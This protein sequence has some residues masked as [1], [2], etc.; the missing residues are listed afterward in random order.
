MNHLPTGKLV[1]LNPSLDCSELAPEQIVCVEDPPA[2]PARNPSPLDF[3]AFS[4]YPVLSPGSTLTKSPII[5]FLNTKDPRR[6]FIGQTMFQ[7]TSFPL[8]TIVENSL[9]LYDSRLTAP[10]GFLYS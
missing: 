2:V 6:S 1:Q 7:C 9:I 3:S 5:D 8:N 4:E 10:Q